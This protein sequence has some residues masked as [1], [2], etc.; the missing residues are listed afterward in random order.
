MCFE[1]NANRAAQAGHVKGILG[2]T[3]GVGR[4]KILVASDSGLNPL[5]NNQ[6]GSGGEGG[7]T[8]L[9]LF[10]LM[11]GCRPGRKAHVGTSKH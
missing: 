3:D 7:T 1:S 5:M 8:V 2:M 6:H 9:S 4:R 10:Y 11:I